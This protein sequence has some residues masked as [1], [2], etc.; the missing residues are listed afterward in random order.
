[1]T[2]RHTG[3][4]GARRSAML[5]CVLLLGGCRRGHMAAV[6]SAADVDSLCA[7]GEARLVIM[8]PAN[9]HVVALELHG[10]DLVRIDID[11]VI[12]N[13]ESL[14]GSLA[15][16]GTGGETKLQQIWS[17]GN[18]RQN[19][20]VELPFPASEGLDQS[21]RLLEAGSAIE[22]TV[23]LSL[24]DAGDEIGATG[25]VKLMFVS[26]HIPRMDPA[27][28][29]VEHEK[30]F[31]YLLSTKHQVVRPDLDTASSARTLKSQLRSCFYLAHILGL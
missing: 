14:D 23:E 20:S 16:F 1:M 25:S 6:P 12:C 13:F 30:P 9:E 21:I 22:Y 19:V 28:P 17:P 5:A 11:I 8:Q 27:S 4:L 24:L 7:T 29:R 10:L 3:A 15:V 26:A 18:G 2:R 31:V